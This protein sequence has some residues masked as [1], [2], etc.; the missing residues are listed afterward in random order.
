MGNFVTQFFKKHSLYFYLKQWCASK[1]AWNIF[2]FF[3]CNHLS[4]LKYI[5]KKHFV[6]CHNVIFPKQVSFLFRGR[7]GKALVPLVLGKYHFLFCTWFL[8]LKQIAVGWSFITS[9]LNSCAAQ[10]AQHAASIKVTWRN[11]FAN[12]SKQ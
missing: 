7:R 5:L 6:S 10:V 9:R 4:S 2:L 3:Y 11:F 1:G 12:F 8:Q